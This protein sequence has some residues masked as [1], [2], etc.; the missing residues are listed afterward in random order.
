MTVDPVAGSN[1]VLLK[2]EDETNLD[3]DTDT[4]VSVETPTAV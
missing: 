4:I 1:D 2:F 3:Y